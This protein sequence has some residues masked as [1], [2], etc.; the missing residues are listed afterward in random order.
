MFTAALLTTGK[1]RDQS[2]CSSTNEQ[3]KK[4]WD[5]YTQW[6][7]IQPQRRMLFSGKLDSESSP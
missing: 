1:I 3:I 2:G 5:I 4:M 6:S 7:I